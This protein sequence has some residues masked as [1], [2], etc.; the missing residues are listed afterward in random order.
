MDPRAGRRRHE[1]RRPV[2]YAAPM[3]TLSQ[4]LA[5]AATRLAA[6]SPSPRPDAEE[7]LSRLLGI[8]RGELALMRDRT[9]DEAQARTFEAW[10]A[11]RERG[12]PVQYVTGRAAFR[13]LDLA[14]GPA[15]LVPRSETEGLVEAVLGVLA[16]ERARWTTPR[17]LDLGTGSG[18]IALAIA[19][20]FPR[21]LVTATDAS[22]AALAVARANTV[23]LGLESRVR[24]GHGEWFEA[25]DADE[26]FEVIVSNPPY[27]A[28]H[29][30]GALPRDVRE[31]EPATA[32]FSGSDGLD[33]LR[34][35]I[36]VAPR[37][38]VTRGLLALELAEVR[39]DEVA[40]WFDGARD[41]SGARVLDDLAGRPRVLLARREAGPAIAPAQW[42]EER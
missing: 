25:V 23:A 1:E 36:E 38:L 2:R 4:S 5:A 35:I 9:L 16:A 33:D 24:F 20:E 27:I 22:E 28:E 12:E 30:A 34:A 11:R 7:L 13:H 42:G 21:A 6:C 15:V 19:S 8:G 10:L 32:L 18:A 17:V 31:W 37:H 41:W 40:A 29:E 39:A 26:R 14:V 3:P